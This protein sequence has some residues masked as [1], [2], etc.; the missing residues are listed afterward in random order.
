[1]KK[2]F[3]LFISVVGLFICG[4]SHA[5]D[6]QVKSDS[7]GPSEK[8]YELKQYFFVMLSVGEKFIQD[9]ATI[10]KIHEGHMANIRRLADMGKLVVAGPFGDMGNWRGFFIF[11]CKT[12]EEAEELVKTDP[13]II[14][15]RMKY[16]IHPW[17]TVKNCVFK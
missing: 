3:I 16:E 13:A 11:D 8:K 1:M 2:T 4:E 14:S 15:G 7:L 9:S 17:W 5:Q 6:K 10:A 12:K